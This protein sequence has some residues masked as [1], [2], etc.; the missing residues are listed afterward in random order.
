MTGI[1]SWLKSLFDMDVSKLIIGGTAVLAAGATWLVSLPIGVGIL[2]VGGGAAYFLAAKPP[3]ALDPTT[4]IPFKLI[5]REELSH[6]TRLFRFA[7]QSDKHVLGLPVGKHMNFSAKVDGKLVVRSYTPVSSDDDIGYFDL[8]IKVYRPAPPK[9]PEGGKLSQ[10][11]DDMKIGD[12]IDVVGPK[13]HIEYKSPGVLNLAGKTKKD[14]TR[15]LNVKHIGMMAGGTGITPCLQLIRDILKHAS[16]NTKVSLIFANKTEE[17]ILLRKEL[18]EAAKDPRFHVWYTL[19]SAPAGWKYSEGFIT[20]D[21]IKEHLP[22]AGPDAHVLMCGPPPMIKFACIPNLE[23]LGF[24][25]TMFS[26]F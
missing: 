23:K 4:K 6:D 8:V 21:M 9:F 18:D 14:P 3:V 24:D 19:D 22:A 15:S 16:D 17:D 2:A 26:S 25:S 12:T 13:G 1:G 11:F 20:E 7:L 10:Y 5:K